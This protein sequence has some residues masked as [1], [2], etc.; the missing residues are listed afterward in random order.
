M[1]LV[2]II[3]EELS[4][5]FFCVE[6]SS[7]ALLILWVFKDVGINTPFRW[8]NFLHEFFVALDFLWRNNQLN[9]LETIIWVHFLIVELNL[10][11]G[12]VLLRFFFFLICFC[13]SRFELALLWCLNLLGSCGNVFSSALG[14]RY[15]RNGSILFDWLLFYLCF[16]QGLVLSFT[17]WK[18]RINID[19]VF[20]E[21]PFVFNIWS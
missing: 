12:E 17:G 5:F 4:R 7:L 15:L 18:E 21:T 10:G 1:I 6:L 19:N 11:R 3:F 2:F 8:L 16:R 13:W 20:E 14:N 9:S